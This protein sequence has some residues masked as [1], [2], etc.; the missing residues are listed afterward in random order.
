M[1]LLAARLRRPAPL[2]GWTY[3]IPVSV[4]VSMNPWLRCGFGH[5]RAETKTKTVLNEGAKQLA[6]CVRVCVR[7]IG[8]SA[9]GDSVGAA[10][11]SWALGSESESGSGR[12]GR[13]GVPPIPIMG[14]RPRCCDVMCVLWECGWVWWVG[15][16]QAAGG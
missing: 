3:D 13:S 6:A 14:I 1:L 9:G 15:V 16:A 8:W 10:G 2:Y 12:G 4:S 11:V 5:L 7:I